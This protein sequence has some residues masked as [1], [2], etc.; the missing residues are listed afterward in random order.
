[1]GLGDARIVYFHGDRKP[2]QLDDEWIVTNWRDSKVA[3][4]LG[5]ADGVQ[6]EWEAAQGLATFDYVVACNDVGTIWPGR[7]DA[8]VTLHPE[9]LPRWIEQRR[10]NGYRDA[11]RYLAHGD[12]LPDWMELVE[13]RFPGQ[14][15]SGSSGLF[16]AKVALIDLGA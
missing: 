11:A 2:H 4:C 1:H 12:Y 8:W 10:A 16:A 5:G 13:F 7:L 15:N 9:Y 14:S 3:L 6:D